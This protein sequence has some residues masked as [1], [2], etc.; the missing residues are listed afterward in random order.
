MTPAF[1]ICII[2]FVFFYSYTA[3]SFFTSLLENVE[4]DFVFYSTRFSHGDLIFYCNVSNIH[5][6]GLY[7]LPSCG[8]ILKCLLTMVYIYYNF[9]TVQ[10]LAANIARLMTN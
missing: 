10:T 5:G 2:Y 9:F 6:M 1:G 7:L 3:A 4:H 8:L